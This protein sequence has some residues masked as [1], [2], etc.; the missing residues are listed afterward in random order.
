MEGHKVVKPLIIRSCVWKSFEN[1]IKR[2]ELWHADTCINVVLV[3]EN[4]EIKHD[5]TCR[6]R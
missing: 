5:E 4:Y 3:V 6:G 1:C 2:H